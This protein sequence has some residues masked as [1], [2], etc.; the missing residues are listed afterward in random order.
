M[1][2][3]QEAYIGNSKHSLISALTGTMNAVIS[4]RDSASGSFQGSLR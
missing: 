2:L 1:L 3:E 4:K